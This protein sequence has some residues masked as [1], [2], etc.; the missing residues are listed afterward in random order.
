MKLTQMRIDYLKCQ[1]GKRDMLVFGPKAPNPARLVQRR[2]AS[3]G[4]QC[5]ATMGDL[6]KGIDP[7]AE[8][9][10]ATAEALRKAA[11]E[12]LTLGALLSDWKRP[13]YAAELCQ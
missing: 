7:A 10:K 9:K 5:R 3:Q 8:R 1:P 4:S 2:L 13:S 12:A 11:H 6:A